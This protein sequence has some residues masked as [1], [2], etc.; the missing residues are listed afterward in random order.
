M[1]TTQH[2]SDDVIARL[3]AR[4]QE[5]LEQ[6][7]VLRQRAEGEGVKEI[8]AL[9][10]LVPLLFPHTV[11]KSYPPAL[12][13]QGRW[14]QMNKWL[15]STSVHRVEVDVEGV[16]DVDSWIERLGEHGHLVSASSGTTGKS[17]SLIH[18]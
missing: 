1:P 3:D 12:V 17:L 11:Y 18:I 13:E 8:G 4:F 16:T 14:A 10:D 2:V 7:P 15:D 9:E 5:R 6:V